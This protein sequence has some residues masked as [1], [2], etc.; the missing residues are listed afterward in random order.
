LGADAYDALLRADHA[1]PLDADDLDRL[2]TAAYLTG[3]DLEFQHILERA[4]GV[5]ETSGDRTR[6]AGSAF[7][8]ALSFL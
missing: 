7:W 2:A 5:H 3:R 4:Y 8:L 1:T 6:A